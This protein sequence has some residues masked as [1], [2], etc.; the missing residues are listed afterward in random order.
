MTL[1]H[2]VY[3]R[4][5][6]QFVHERE[7]LL[8]R[9]K[10]MP[11]GGIVEDVQHIGATSVPGVPAV[12]CVDVLLTV[13][14]FPLEAVHVEA[15]TAL[16]YLPI[17]REE[18]AP[19]QRF[20]HGVNPI[21][22]IFVQ[23]GSSYATDALVLRDFLRH[24]DSAR[25]LY[26]AQK[27]TRTTVAGHEA[28]AAHFLQ[29]RE[30]AHAWWIGHHGFNPL[31]Q[32]TNELADFPHP[33]YIS[34]GWA[35]DLFLGQ[36]TRVHQDV[37]VVLPRIHQLDLQAY[38]LERGWQ[39]VT[40]LQGRLEPW[41]LHMRIELPRHQIHAHRHG[42]FIDFLLTDIEYGVWRYR[43][44]PTIVQTVERMVMCGALQ[45]SF[46]APELV[47]LFKSKNTGD[48]PRPQDQSDFDRVLSH[49]SPDRR[50]WLRW[51]LS[52]LEPDHPW[53]EQLG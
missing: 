46:L 27:M 32:V 23:A 24:D 35:L 10:R 37:D 9:L 13:S 19:E 8:A 36:V 1:Q 22:L 53:L 17:L 33:W 45:I 18:N 4:W 16:G 15:L 51:A 43:R 6:E 25:R 3:E 31:Q 26:V 14:P 42:A 40:P 41:P 39:F 49:L 28:K 21:Q 20:R 12:P 5:H 38:M 52:V 11:E 7:R 34:S 50:A 2:D 29:W 44:D 47:L 48:Q 30:Q